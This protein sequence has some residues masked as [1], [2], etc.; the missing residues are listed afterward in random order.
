MSSLYT[1][2]TELLAL[3]YQLAKGNIKKNKNKKKTE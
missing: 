2:N 1:D 3:V